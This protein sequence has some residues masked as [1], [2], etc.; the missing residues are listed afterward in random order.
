MFDID[1]LVAFVF[2]GL[3]F[4][5]QTS[6]L[7]QPNKINYAPLMLG[8]GAL[9][10]VVHFM[11]QPHNSDIFLVLKG[12]LSPLFVSLLLYM[13]MNIMHQTQQSEQSKIQFEFTKALIEQITQLKEFASDLEKAMITNQNEDRLAQHDTREKFKKD[14]KVLEAIQINQDKFLEKFDEMQRWHK[15]ITK[16]FENFTE[17]QLPSL[18]DV[19]HKH[20]DILRIT[21]QDHFNKVK[22]TL[23]KAVDDRDEMIG[24]LEGL[25]NSVITISSTV[26]QDIVSSVS[27]Q[28]LE[29]A[30]IFEKQ[31]ISLKSHTESMNTALYESES[32]LSVIKEQSEIIMKQM[33]LSSKKMSE[34]K[35]QNSGLHDTYHVVKD[36]VSEI[37]DI[38][39]DYVKAQA[40]LTFIVRDM[41]YT[42][43]K[44]IEEMKSQIDDLS[45]SL[46]TKIEESIEKLHE[47]YHI[48]G[49][50]ITESVQILSKKI[51]LQKGYLS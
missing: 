3:L 22:S 45:H 31:L 8:I 39:T 23:Q 13:I 32:K 27:G 42:E 41:R 35:E 9:S 28:L 29:V 4:L 40:E 26:S 33:V 46:S 43:I 47:H 17:V 51:N 36:L 14:I 19:F 15:G 5:R 6:I 50:N 7:K 44:H 16:L 37:E 2:M 21:E 24:D 11:I 12:S 30:K 38:K 49:D 25:K 34:I 48:A 1:L 18:D 10:G 20:I